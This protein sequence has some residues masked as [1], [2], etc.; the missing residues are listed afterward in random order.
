[1]DTLSLSLPPADGIWS[2]CLAVLIDSGVK[3]AVLLGVA[4]LIVLSL[5]RASA[6]TR[7]LVWALA[8][9][10]LL[11][12]PL[13]SITMP[14]L[15]LPILPREIKPVAQSAP[16]PAPRGEVVAT[17]AAPG[18]AGPAV[19]PFVATQAAAH[20]PFAE[21]PSEAKTPLPP[22]FWA[23]AA[24]LAL[25]GLILLPLGGGMI[26]VERMA[27]AGRPME[28]P[29]RGLARKLAESLG[30]RRRVRVLAA[31]PQT[32]PMAIGLF[33]ATVLMPDGAN[34]WP[35]AKRRAVL[36]HELAHVKR[37]DCLTHAVARVA[38]ALHWFNPLAWVALRRMR[39]ERERAC[40]DLVLTAG[41]RP[42]TYADHLLE[43][44][45]T[46]QAG[47]LA[48]AA[49]ITMAKR[50]QLEGRL[51]A[52]LDA[53]RNRGAIRKWVLILGLILL[54]LITIPL[55]ALKIGEARVFSRMTPQEKAEFDAWYAQKLTIPAEATHPE[56]FSPETLQTV[57]DF[58]ALGGRLQDI[59]S[60]FDRNWPKESELNTPAF[61]EFIEKNRGAIGEGAPII[62]MF[63]IVLA[64]PDYSI[65][66]WN[67]V[68]Y[69]GAATAL[70]RAD[71]TMLRRMVRLV[72]LDSL[73]NLKDGRIDE[74][75][76]DADALVGFA[77]MRP[78]SPLIG[79]MIAISVLKYGLGAYEAIG[80][81]T[82]DPEIRARIAKDLARHRAKT[83]YFPDT[84]INPLVMDQIG[85]TA[86]ARRLG[87][88][89]NFD[90]KSGFEISL[91]TMRV[92]AE[93][94]EKFALPKA[95]DAAE[96]DQIQK[97][98]DGYR[99]NLKSFSSPSLIGRWT[100]PITA[101]TL[102]SIGKPGM[103]KADEVAAE[104]FKRYD[105]LAIG[106]QHPQQPDPASSGASFVQLRS[107][108][109][110]PADQEMPLTAWQPDGSTISDSDTL[111]VIRTYPLG[112]TLKPS[113]GKSN[114]AFLR[115]FCHDPRFDDH[116]IFRFVFYNANHQHIQSLGGTANEAPDTHEQYP[117]WRG[118]ILL[119]EAAALPKTGQV[120]LRYSDGPWTYLPVRIDPT[121][122]GKIAGEIF[123]IESITGDAKSTRIAYVVKDSRAENDTQYEAVA[124]TDESGTE[125][126]TRHE[127]F[128][129]AP[130]NGARYES[131]FP[132][133]LADVKYF[134]I[135]KR[136]IER[137][138]FDNV[139]FA[140]KL[141]PAATSSTV[142]QKR[143]E[144]MQARLDT[145]KKNYEEAAA[146]HKAGVVPRE[147]VS[148]AERDYKV[149]QAELA[150]DPVAAAQARYDAAV[151]ILA[152]Q[153]QRYEHGLANR[154]DVTSAQ[155]A[156]KEADY[157]LAKAKAGTVKSTETIIST[158]PTDRPPM[159]EIR[160][161][162]EARDS[163]TTGTLD[164]FVHPTGATRWVPR[165]PV[166]TGNDVASVDL[167]PAPN[168]RYDVLIKLMK[169]DSAKNDPIAILAGITAENQGQTLAIA[170]NGRILVEMPI[171]HEL[172]DGVLVAASNLERR[173]AVET[174]SLLKFRR[175][176]YDTRFPKEVRFYPQ[177]KMVEFDR[178]NYLIF[179]D[180]GRNTYSG[181]FSGGRGVRLNVV[182]D[183][184]Y[185]EIDLT[186]ETPATRLASQV[187]EI[188]YKDKDR[189][190]ISSR[191]G[192]RGNGTVVVNLATG[193]IEERSDDLR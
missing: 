108:N 62:K 158:N 21:P 39:I 135:R 26:A 96:R 19:E 51:L 33:R 60:A 116:S 17:T 193:K 162:F 191:L 53:G 107:I 141:E 22:A 84:K 171:A 76:D 28:E 138:T 155:L 57:R 188:A 95:A 59:T 64:R 55:A 109:A 192:H 29:W 70:P 133:P 140:P 189:V 110:W 4:A 79:K 48:S 34:R 128:G 10:G 159:D 80:N 20:A 131:R 160:R 152:G 123:S 127:T 58:S 147:T 151:T 111:A 23:V 12:L 52:I 168:G 31:P 71:Y 190:S 92:N 125:I 43:I 82:D 8:L 185:K 36:L 86:E 182:R 37:R 85:F 154:A 146:R 117:G 13:L 1:M 69:A 27:R 63:K 65:N 112:Q 156:V 115:V 126:E 41:E 170:A 122:Q 178:N 184:Q 44:A 102:Y 83:K 104:A 5:R 25:A 121:F 9:D 157:E 181:G 18:V 6:A 113:P 50:S 177:W 91:E 105:A 73:M 54:L 186:G 148:L 166:L 144:L 78:Y 99:K 46:M 124:I 38:V 2:Q 167:R 139:A 90:N 175:D 173:R 100:N 129:S 87:L 98:I 179:E 142:D 119:F 15:Q 42:A 66:V 68:P 163:P 143:R 89:A 11:L 24:W 165:N 180:V 14:S 47:T 97:A 153:K 30:L 114:Q 94:L 145:A 74:A 45:R 134:I 56:T 130:P 16:A 101:A 161:K 118:G 35:D 176:E 93:Y 32:M 149:A 81:R 174:A 40:D 77:H 88:S 61:A 7:H 49:A 169:G 75:L 183:G 120:E 137:V 132:V 67:T 187:W 103:D 106:I 150:G 3:G 172:K 136:P 164:F 72:Y